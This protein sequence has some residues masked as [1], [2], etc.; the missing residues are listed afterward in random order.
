MKGLSARAAVKT[1][2]FVEEESEE[3]VSESGTE[4]MISLTERAFGPL[5]DIAGCRPE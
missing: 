2:L 5:V 4:K 3:E 1:G